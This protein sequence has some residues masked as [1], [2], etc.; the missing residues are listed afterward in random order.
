LK[1][2]Y[3]SKFTEQTKPLEFCLL[4]EEMISE[5]NDPH[6]NIW[7]PEELVEEYKELHS[8]E[9]KDTTNYLEAVK[10][11]ILKNY[12]DEEKK[13]N[14]GIVVYGK[15]NEYLAYIRLNE[16]DRLADYGF[17][18]EFSWNAY[19]DKTGASND[20]MQDNID[21]VHSLM[22]SVIQNISGTKACIIDLRFNSGGYD[23]AGLAFLSHFIKSEQEVYKKKRRIWNKTTDG[24]TI[25]I[26]PIGPFYG[27]SVYILTSPNT[28][29]A[30]ETMVL[31]TLNFPNFKRVGATTKG[32]FSDLLEKQLPN[33]WTYTLS[34]E[35]YETM[36]GKVYESIGIPPDYKID[37][38]KESDDLFKTMSSELETK[39]SALEKIINL[40]Q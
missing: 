11:K 38:P 7:L 29:S 21:G 6:S 5:L 14:N 32:A 15:I 34:T 37:Y 8:T 20:E 17:G 1:R 33:G 4:L 36:D 35:I 40:E 26:K 18:N 12:V 24:K 39:D 25:V 22:K 16:M 28:V 30:A 2:K 19:W 13:Y 10:T 23:D 27:K 31:T 3:R 9:E